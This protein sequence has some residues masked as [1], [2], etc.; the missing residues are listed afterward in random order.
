MLENS[1][2]L[3]KVK[4]CITQL[5]VSVRY[6]HIKFLQSSLT[7]I[8]S[9]SSIGEIFAILGLYWNF[10][11]CG[12]LR[13]IIRRLGDR[14]TKQLMGE[15]SEKLKSFR[16][17]TK[18]GDFI[19]KW[20]GDCNFCHKEFCTEMGEE[21]RERSLED[22]EKFRMR[23][24]RQMSFTDYAVLIRKVG[25]GS[26]I[27]S[28]VLQ[29]SLLTDTLFLG[30]LQLLRESNIQRVISNGEVIVELRDPKVCLK[31]LYFFLHIYVRL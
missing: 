22:L 28:W 19:N 9:A 20:T 31:M 1:Q 16:E 25:S 5:P 29:H 18:L 30:A 21:W 26:V 7:A 12:L 27:V 3:K 24:S 4:R 10:L 23:F 13:E 6:Q 15:Y 11:N 17:R 8:N 2:Q 14:K